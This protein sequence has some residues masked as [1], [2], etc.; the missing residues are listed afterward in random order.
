MAKILFL[1][2]RFPFPADK[3][4]K[5]RIY[6]QLVHLSKHHSVHL[7]S[8]CEQSVRNEDHEAMSGICASVHSHYLPRSVRY[9]QLFMSLFTGLPFQVAYFY[10]D[11]IRE[12][13]NYLIDKLQPDFIHCHLIRTTEY[14]RDIKGYATSLD[15]M[16][17]FGEGMAKRAGYE[18]NLLKRWFFSFEKRKVVRYES[19]VLNF[20]DRFCIISDQDRKRIPGHE[21]HL[22]NIVRNG[23]DFNIFYPREVPKRYDLVFMGNL[24]YPPNLVAIRFLLDEIMPGL[25]SRKPEIRLL[26]A[27]A[28]ASKKLLR[29]QSK[30]V[31]VLLNFKD[32]SDSIAWSK[33]L[34]AP[35]ITSIGLQ[36]KIIQA[37]AMKVPCVVS[38]IAN[39]AIGAPSPEA[40]RVAA[41]AAEYVTAIFDLLDNEAQM[42]ETGQKGY[43]FVMKHFRWSSCTDA[44]EKTILGEDSRMKQK[45]LEVSTEANI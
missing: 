44:L 11:A 20:I 19:E 6:H 18:R 45:T 29:Y 12:R 1:T 24:D 37:M 32:I 42:I 41:N 30:N 27:G 34:I 13:L 7:F 39:K 21:K 35:M 22:I 38:I 2:S 36:N 5:L 10:N 9:L 25:V 8:L 23:V 33:I 15:F 17:A 16:D 31:D 43:E 40:I 28:G 14:V 3:G 4:D 26:L